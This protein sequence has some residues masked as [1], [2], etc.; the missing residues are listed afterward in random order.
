M[1]RITGPMATAFVALTLGA[2]GAAWAQGGHT[3]KSPHG[4]DI[5]EVAN[6]HIEFKA[7]ST[8]AIAV[9][10]LDEKQMPLAPPSGATVTLMPKGGEQVTLP[11]Q[12]DA[13]GQRLTA[14]FDAKKLT[15]FQAVVRMT[16][17]GTKR[18]LRFH[19]P[20]H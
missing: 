14:H 15:A 19:H 12:V 3:H 18:N 8:G 11:L 5:L 13:A 4:G 6:H 7:D 2:G 9:W 17:A 20:S 1:L 16:V 10:L